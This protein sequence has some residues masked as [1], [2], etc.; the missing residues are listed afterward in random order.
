MIT[1]N[2]TDKKDTQRLLWDVFKESIP[3]LSQSKDSFG[4]IINRLFGTINDKDFKWF[5]NR[6]SHSNYI[7]VRGHY[8][9]DGWK[10]VL[11][12]EVYRLPTPPDFSV[13]FRAIVNNA[14]LKDKISTSHNYWGD[15]TTYVVTVQGISDIMKFYNNGT[16]IPLQHD[17]IVNVNYNNFDFLEKYK[18]QFEYLKSQESKF[19]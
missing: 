18:K 5:K 3:H 2:L 16:K 10:L 13:R 1:Y 9:K 4:E 6:T 7:N 19:N 15:F 14:I 12:G 8:I 17:V 11:S